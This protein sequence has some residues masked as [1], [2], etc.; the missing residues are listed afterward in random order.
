MDYRYI[1]L[2]FFCSLLLFLQLCELLEFHKEDLCLC[3]WGIFGISL[4]VIPGFLYFTD[5]SFW[6]DTYVLSCNK[7][8]A[9]FIFYSLSIKTTTFSLIGPDYAISLSI[10]HLFMLIILTIFEV[11]FGLLRVSVFIQRI[12]VVLIRV[13]KGFVPSFGKAE[14]LLF[15]A[16]ESA[17]LLYF[18]F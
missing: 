8:S 5:Y 4:L 7:D 9:I 14:L 12:L 6:S 13:I 3:K 11:L 2:L 17:L 1:C 16:V 10:F 18:Y 15:L